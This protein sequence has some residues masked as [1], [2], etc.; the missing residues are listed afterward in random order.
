MQQLFFVL[1]FVAFAFAAPTK[2]TVLCAV[3][4]LLITL[5]VVAVTQAVAGTSTTLSSAFKAVFL[6]LCFLAVWLLTLLSYLKGGDRSFHELSLVVLLASLFGA[7]VMGFKV[8][9]PLTFRSSAIV[10]VLSTGISGALIW[11]ARS[12][13]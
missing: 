1:A 2:V 12:Y 13:L 4:L 5:T 3:L 7:F 6:S 10:A 11:G 9:L 8:A